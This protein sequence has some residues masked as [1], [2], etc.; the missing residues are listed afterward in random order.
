[1]PQFDFRNWI[2]EQS[3][4][5]Q[6]DAS[7]PDHLKLNTEYAAAEINFYELENEPEIAEFRIYNH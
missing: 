5:Y 1:M 6:L 3:G 4:E 2:K 7:D